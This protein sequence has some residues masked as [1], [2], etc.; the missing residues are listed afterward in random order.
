MIVMQRRIQRL[1]KAPKE[2]P[3]DQEMAQSFQDVLRKHDTTP[4]LP[5]KMLLGFMRDGRL[6]VHSPIRVEF[7]AE[8]DQIVAQAVEFNEFGF[9]RNW[10]EALVD[11]QHAIDELYFTLEEGQDRLGSDLRTMWAT[12]QQKLRKR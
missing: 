5:D 1:D 11:L 10:S 4:V 2:Q 8:N 7:I 12:L 6:Q 3:G 9:G